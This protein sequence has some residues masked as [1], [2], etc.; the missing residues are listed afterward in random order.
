MNNVTKF[1]EY[2]AKTMKDLPALPEGGKKFLVD[3]A[4]WFS[5]VGG[6][7]MAFVTYQIWNWAHT[8]SAINDLYKTYL[9]TDV[10]P[11]MTAALW[12]YLVFY[13]AVAVVY[14]MAFAPL[15]A[16]KIAG[17]RLLFIGSLLTLGMGIASIF[18]D[19]V[20]GMN[21]F[22]AII[23]TAISWY[24]LFQIRDSYT[25]AKAVTPAKKS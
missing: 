5:L 12:V 3:V 19:Y 10:A 11:G 15:K 14:L 9:G 2:L 6:L 8:Y 25:G 23:S 22:S 4:P 24:L 16:K 17:W 20:G 7:I 21:I 13:V 18:A 1:E